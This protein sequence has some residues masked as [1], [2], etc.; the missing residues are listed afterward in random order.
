M[1]QLL[2][3]LGDRNHITLVHRKQKQTEPVQFI[4]STFSIPG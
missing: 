2:Y 4:A 3:K 1:L